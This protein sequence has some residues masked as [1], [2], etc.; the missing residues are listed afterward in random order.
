MHFEPTLSM[1]KPFLA[2]DSPRP[3]LKSILDGGGRGERDMRDS[4]RR[5][6]PRKA[7]IRRAVEAI[8]NLRNLSGRDERTDR[9][10]AAVAWSK[11]GSEPESRNSVSVGLWMKGS[12]PS[13]S[14]A[15]IRL[16]RIA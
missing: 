8:R 6:G 12:S 5:L 15:V 14:P 10:Q 1:P 7:I 13:R 4:F 16:V 11:I 2:W 9:H 3:F